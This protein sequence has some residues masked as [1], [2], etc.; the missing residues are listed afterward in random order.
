MPI[1]ETRR[2][3]EWREK[4]EKKKG[5]GQRAKP[6]TPTLAIDALI[7]EGEQNWKQKKEQKKETGREVPSQTTIWSHLIT[8]MDHAVGLF[9]NS[10]LPP[11]GILLLLRSNT[12][13]KHSKVLYR[14]QEKRKNRK[15][16]K[17]KSEENVVGFK[18]LAQ[19]PYSPQGNGRQSPTVEP[20]R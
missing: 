15:T 17:S 11:G 16:R 13:R 1:K 3:E 19:P 2:K 10:P 8:H 7:R 5:S 14:R 6:P 4:S 12:S 20:G 9:W 18:L